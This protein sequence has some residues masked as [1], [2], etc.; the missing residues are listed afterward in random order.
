MNELTHAST[1]TPPEL[2]GSRGISRR[3]VVR[4]AAWS[5][6][7]ITVMAASPALAASGT[8]VITAAWVSD[9]FRYNS[10]ATGTSGTPSASAFG[11]VAI[12]LTVTG[13][14]VDSLTC[15]LST[16]GTVQISNNTATVARGGTTWAIG[17]GSIAADGWTLTPSTIP[18][19]QRTAWSFNRG[20]TGPGNYRLRVVFDSIGNT[21][22]P[23]TFAF[24]SGSSASTPT[25][26]ATAS[27]TTPFITGAP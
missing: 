15:A 3:A 14:T 17:N 18:S 13:G 21:D 27:A 19:G 16:T 24:S 8:P 26:I 6:P 2:A 20:T 9:S 23:F 7:V 4:T 1:Q 10:N 5:A 25:V 22:L 12:A 11:A